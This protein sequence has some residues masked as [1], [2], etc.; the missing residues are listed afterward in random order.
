MSITRLFYAQ[1]WHL[2]S[3][4]FFSK[5]FWDAKKFLLIW[6]LTKQ[7]FFSAK[8]NFIFFSINSIHEIFKFLNKILYSLLFPGKS[9][10]EIPTVGTSLW[11]FLYTFLYFCRKQVFLG[12]RK[13][14]SRSFLQKKLATLFINFAFVRLKQILPFHTV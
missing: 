13:F 3:F 5:F 7:I 12:K 2:P 1:R 4:L 14:F 6:F 8:L 9:S 10:T 11:C